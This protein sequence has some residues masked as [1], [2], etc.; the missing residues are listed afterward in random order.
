VHALLLRF[1]SLNPHA[2]D[3]IERDFIGAPVVKLGGA[4]AGVIGHACRLFERATDLTPVSDPTSQREL[5]ACKGKIAAGAGGRYP[6]EL[7][8]LI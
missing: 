3:L 6:S 1:L 4:G 5:D 2:L 7:C 8:G